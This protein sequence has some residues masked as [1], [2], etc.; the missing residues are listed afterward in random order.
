L[1]RSNNSGSAPVS[2]NQSA[3]TPESR[4]RTVLNLP[5]PQE[6]SVDC[7]AGPQLKGDAKADARGPGICIQAPRNK[8][9]HVRS[10]GYSRFLTRV[11]THIAL[12][13]EILSVPQ[14]TSLA[15][16]STFTHAVCTSQSRSQL[17][18]LRTHPPP[19][20]LR[21]RPPSA[22]E[23]C[24]GRILALPR[25]NCWGSECRAGTSGSFSPFFSSGSLHCRRGPPRTF[26]H[27]EYTLRNSNAIDAAV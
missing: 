9:T 22:R 5:P 15:R 18:M 23:K 6:R 11:E 16:S 3:V 17:L 7:L 19:M 13:D 2:T 8:D 25:S 26:K 1:G 20:G 27:A 21:F 14:T 12:V 10:K 4:G 24:H